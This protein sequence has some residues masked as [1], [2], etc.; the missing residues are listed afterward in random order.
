ML[1]ENFMCLS[2]I[3]LKMEW[4]GFLWKTRRCTRNKFF[5]SRGNSFALNIVKLLIICQACAGEQVLSNNRSLRQ[6]LALAGLGVGIQID[7]EINI[8]QKPIIRDVLDL[9]VKKRERDRWKRKKGSVKFHDERFDIAVDETTDIHLCN[10]CND[11]VL[12]F[13]PKSHAILESNCTD[14]NMCMIA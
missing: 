9:N 6:N 14:C 2:G 7:K 13:N 10:P 1:L 4:I 12:D 11:S 8:S 5:L 3:Q